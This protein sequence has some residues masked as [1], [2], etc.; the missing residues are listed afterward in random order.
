MSLSAWERQVLHSIK[1]EIAVSDPEL[2]ALL[3][4]FTRLASDEEMPSR[5]NVSAD[6]RRTIRRLRRARRRTSLR[7]AC[8]RLG[9]RRAALLSL[10][11]LTTAVLVAVIVAVLTSGGD[12]GSSCTETAIIACADLAPGHSA[13]SSPPHSTTG[14]QVPRQ[15]A[16]NVQAGP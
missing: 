10:W 6:P 9:F 15:Q 5:E 11:L 8:Y 12:H 7:K 2:T 13:G 14:I 16:G 4:A 1:C 3:Y